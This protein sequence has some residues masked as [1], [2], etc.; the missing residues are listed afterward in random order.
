LA[1]VALVA[2]LVITM[3]LLVTTQYLQLLLLL[4]VAVAVQKM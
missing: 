4:V 2:Q 3:E 1:L